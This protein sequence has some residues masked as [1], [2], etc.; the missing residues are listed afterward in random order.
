MTDEQTD[1]VEG[2]AVAGYPSTTADSDKSNAQIIAERSADISAETAK[3]NEHRKV[4]VL[5]PGPKPT[6]AN[7]YDHR[8]NY[9]ATREY[10][11]QQGL[12]PTGDVRLVS[13]TKF[14]PG[15]VS[16]ALT[17]AVPVLPAERVSYP[18]PGAAEVVTEHETDE[19][20]NVPTNSEGTGNTPN[21]DPA[22]TEPGAPSQPTE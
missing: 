3:N 14:G 16:W 19:S 10:A 12:R 7:G 8:A 1:A 15:G 9:A 5:P 17:Y 11:I 22:G 18:E 21:T 2:V 4:F 13:C 6:E 20:G